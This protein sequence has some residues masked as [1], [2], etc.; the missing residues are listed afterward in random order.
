MASLCTIVTAFYNFP[1]KKYHTNNYLMWMKAFLENTN[2][3]M[4]IYTDSQ[5]S[6]NI[7]SDFRKQ[8]I[9]KTKIIIEPFQNLYCAKYQN[10]WDKDL[11][12]DH[13]RSYHNQMLYVIWNEKTMFMY[14]TYK[15][16]PFNTEYFAWMDIGMVRNKEYIKFLNNFPSSKRLEEI[17]KNKVHLV[18][19]NEFTNEE[20]Y[21]SVPS[22][23]FRYV[24]RLGAGMILCHIDIIERWKNEYYDML[25]MFMNNN[26][27]SGKDQSIVNSLYIKYKDE[28]IELVSTNDL[29]QIDNKWFYMLYFLSDY[30][31]D[32]K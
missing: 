31:V 15:M 16:N 20:L 5:E 32:I 8:F 11:Q 10:Y 3:Y 6:C 7:I 24:D 27:F 4:V 1:A 23:I 14:K 13:E 25:N 29:R 12:R 18:V 2:T 9:E 17:N 26:L 30:F 21:S 22:E 19:I 28:F